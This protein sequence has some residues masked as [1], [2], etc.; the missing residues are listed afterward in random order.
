[1]EKIKLLHSSR[2]KKIFYTNEIIQKGME[3][4]A[5]YFITLQHSL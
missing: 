5:V 3:K 4:I 1:M 2:N